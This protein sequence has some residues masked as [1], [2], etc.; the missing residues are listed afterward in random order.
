VGLLHTRGQLLR[1]SFKPNT[2]DLREAPSL[3]IARTLNS[4]GARTVGCDPAPA[5][6]AMELV[7]NLT[8]VFDAYEVLERSSRCA[9]RHRVGGGAHLGVGHAVAL[10]EAPKL[11]MDGR[12]A[13][14]LNLALE[15]GLLY[16]SF[17]RG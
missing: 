17:S 15:A 9:N 4:L 16:R 12:N 5:K 10:L 2:D 7:P 3:H 6:K 1:F 8:I 14:E 11:L 13:L